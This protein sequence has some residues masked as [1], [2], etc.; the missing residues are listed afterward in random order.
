MVKFLSVFIIIVF[1]TTISQSVDENKLI[2]LQDIDYIFKTDLKTWNQNTLFLDK[3]SS[4][5]KIKLN[6]ISSYSLK[7]FFNDG[8]VIITPIFKDNKVS[9]L[10]LHYKFDTLDKK[11][12]NYIKS[13][14]NI[15]SNIY[16]NKI[17]LKNNDIFIDLYIC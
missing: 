5:K 11:S 2:H 12:L 6:N 15:L 14:F 1:Y 9:I 3:K 4:M 13:H 8:F 16:C 17:K 10:N 7:T